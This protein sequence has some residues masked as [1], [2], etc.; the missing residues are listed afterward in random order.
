MAEENSFKNKIAQQRH[1]LLGIFVIVV[2]VVLK[3][4]LAP[5]FDGNINMLCSI[6]GTIFC[7]VGLYLIVR[8]I[9]ARHLT[10]D[11]NPSND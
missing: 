2:G 11:E 5:H 9:Y 8:G 7:L 10:D 1:W 3:R 6:A 4:S